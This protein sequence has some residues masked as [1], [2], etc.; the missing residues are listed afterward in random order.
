MLKAFTRRTSP[1][2]LFSQ[3]TP[4]RPTPH[5]SSRSNS[6][7][8]Y[9]NTKTRP[10]PATTKA[11]LFLPST[12]AASL[13]VFVFALLDDDEKENRFAKS[14]PFSLWDS[15]DQKIIKP[16]QKEEEDMPPPQNMLPGRAGNLTKE[17]EAKLKELWTA[18]LVV[19]GVS[20]PASTPSSTTTTSPPATPAPVVESPEKKKKL[21]RF[22]SRRGKPEATPAATTEKI[23]NEVAAAVDTSDDKY[24]QTKEFKAALASQT[25]AE[26]REAFWSMVKHDNPDGLLLRFLRARKW[27]VDKALVMMVATMNWRSKEMNVQEV[28][29]KGEEAYAAS[30]DQGF[31]KQL[32]MGKSFLHGMDKEGRPIC[33][34]RVRLHKQAD[35]SE[36][37]LEKYTVY[38]ME[39][40]R[41]MLRDPVDTAAVVFD[42]SGFSM[43]NMDYAPVKYLIKCFEA[44]YPESL[45]VCLVHKAPWIFQSIWSIIRGWLDPVVASKIHFTKSVEDMEAYIPRSNILKELGG[46]DDWSYTYVEPVPGE[47]DAMVKGAEV[48]EVLLRKRE[49]QVKEFEQLTKKWVVGEENQGARARVTEELRRGYWELDKYLRARTVYDRTGVFGEGGRLEMYKYREGKGKEVLAERFD[50]ID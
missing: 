25:P 12:I 3:L 1:R 22:L 18:T 49:G 38:I 9:N 14:L 8:A 47:N 43:A 17:E 42:M 30:P 10:L 11:A 15:P 13:A 31:I 33:F 26:L 19:F 7:G 50:E 41:L 23:A 4:N 27:D 45:G 39:T 34:V 35:Q 24:G 37:A 21:G 20:S 29:S 16:Q 46:D 32:R 36:E 44:H 5:T 28:V 40:A 2:H 6:S 48:K